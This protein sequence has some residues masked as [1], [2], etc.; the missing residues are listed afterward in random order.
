MCDP[1][2][3]IFV[4]FG[5]NAQVRWN[6]VHRLERAEMDKNND[7]CSTGPVRSCSRL[8]ANSGWW[9][10]KDSGGG[11]LCRSRSTKHHKDDLLYARMLRTSSKQN[12][13]HPWHFMPLDAA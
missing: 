12:Q 3:I 9:G 13:Q 10:K 8:D 5:F 11:A 2:G 1:D 7:I 6:M 4:S